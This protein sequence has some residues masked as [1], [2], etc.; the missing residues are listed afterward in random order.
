VIKESSIQEIFETAKIEDVVQDYVRLKRRG[1]NLIGLCPFHTEK[2]PSFTVSPSKNIYK[3][4]GCGEGGD[5]VKFI[6][7]HLQFSFPEALRHLAARYNIEI[8]ETGNT[9]EALA[10]RQYLDSLYIVNQYARDYYQQ[11]LFESD[12]GRSVGLSY[13]KDRGFREETIRKYGLGY[14]PNG[15]DTFTQKAQTDGYDIDLLRKLGLTTQYNRDF[16]RNRVLFAIHNFSGKVIGF[17]GRILN[18]DLKA[19]KYINTPETDIYHKSKVLYGVYFAKRAIR[20][21]DQCILVEGYTDVISLHQAG[22]ENVVAASGTSLTEEQIRLIKR[23]TPNIKMLFDGDYAGTKAALR[24]LDMVLEQGLNV[25]IVMLPEGEDPDSY[26]QSVGATAFGEY[27]DREARDFILFKADLL[28]RD[29]AGDPI[30]KTNAIRDI[31]GSIAR[32]PD[33]IKRSLFIQE[34][35]KVVEVDEQ[36]L[37]TEVN[38]LV[39]HALRKQA[40][41]QERK[42]ANLNNIAGD[43]PG[44]ADTR[45]LPDKGMERNT[46][47]QFQEKD[48]VRILISGGEKWFDEADGIT[49]ADFVLAN[50]GDVLD[51]F[52][53]PVYQLIVKEA[54]DL[55]TKDQAVTS[56]FFI[57][58]RDERVKK[59]TIDLLSSPYEYSENWAKRWEIFLQTQK[60]PEEN[61]KEDAL[62]SLRRFKLRKLERM[63]RRNKEKIKEAFENNSEEYLIYLQVDQRLK[64]QR[65]QLAKDLGSVILK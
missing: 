7:E 52:D 59:L 54:Y 17:G 8:E 13:F 11:Q 21:E 63:I 50:I 26:L 41:D 37:V 25:Q 38:K 20:K 5:P 23:L 14:A 57:H 33:P 58:H 15:R 46:G 51:E 45:F 12:R 48:I 6:M 4:F 24:G 60:M 2:T 32:I 27:I 19:P 47:D 64:E 30:K 16:F 9:E 34:C 28:L 31:V 29:A 35:A 65:N 18:K 44:Q 22:I 40:G 42:T 36:L 49:V 39:G 61:F 3:C 56:Q 55:L 62:Y 43:N 1:A 10:E 53:S